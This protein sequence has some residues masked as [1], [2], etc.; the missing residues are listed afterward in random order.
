MNYKQGYNESETGGILLGQIYTNGEIL[1][2]ICS[3]PCIAGQANRISFSRSSKIANKIINDAFEGSNGTILYVGEWHTH[4]EPYPRPSAT[5]KASIEEIYQ[6]TN[7]N[8]SILIYVI[9]G[10]SDIFC[11]VYDGNTHYQIPLVISHNNQ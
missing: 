11:G 7:I 8:D 5:D 3:E 2:C 1:V 6:T 10:V 9:V 4:P